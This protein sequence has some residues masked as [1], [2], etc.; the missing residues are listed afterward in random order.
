M[1]SSRPGIGHLR[2]VFRGSLIEPADGAYDA[3]RRIWNGIFDR[4]PAL[5]ARCADA[6]DTSA[7][8]K[9]ATKSGLPV[10][11]RGGGHNVAGQALADGAVLIDLSLM[12]HVEVD[13]ARR[14]ADA[15]GGCLLRDLDSATTPHGLACPVGVVSHTGLGGLA[16]GG[17]YGWLAR[18]WGLTCDH[19]VAAQVVLADGSIVEASDD[20][21]PDL[22]WALRGGG[23]NFGVVTR[24]TLRL[25]PVGTMQYRVA[26]Y[27]VDAAHDVMETWRSFAPHQVDGVHVMFSLRPRYEDDWLP[28]SLRGS[29]CLTLTMVAAD[30][31]DE[32]VEQAAELL[33][34]APSAASIVRRLPYEEL[35]S[36]D[37]DAEPPGR[38]YFT[39]SCYLTDVPADMTRHLIESIVTAPSPFS[40]IAVEYWRGAIAAPN[41][42][43]A[44]AFPNR[45]APFMC[46]AS[47]AWLHPQDDSGNCAWAR[48]AIAGLPSQSVRRTYTNY[49]SPDQLT[50]HVAQTYGAALHRRLARVKAEYD[51]GNLFH[52][53][54]N[55]LPAR[56]AE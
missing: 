37:D 27:P 4:R 20:S 47:A 44:S 21:H 3:A 52:S 18:T 12:R 54:P 8:L 49:M 48:Q 31:D 56:E 2:W 33:G 13:R 55:V 30:D 1:V 7:V 6:D 53:N 35:Q 10:S 34:K 11:V 14:V 39:K 23:G 42:S 36:L 19:I 24:F 43:A 15:D 5:I 29:S 25:R 32:G 40:S 9:F 22:L 51:P 50:S 41:A 28:A 26:A 17:G 16:L 38:R 46:T 45:D